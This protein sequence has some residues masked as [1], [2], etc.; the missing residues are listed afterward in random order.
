VGLDGAFGFDTTMWGGAIIA[1][2]RVSTVLFFLPIFGGEG[3]PFRVRVLLGL[4]VTFAIW[5][6]AAATMDSSFLKATS[7]STEL[8][9]ASVREVFL[10]FAIGFSCKLLLVAVSIAAN[11]I[12][13]N[14]GFQ[15]AATISPIFQ[16]QDSVLAV[17]KNW[18]VLVLLLSLN[19]HHRFLELI[20]D[21]FKSVPVSGAIRADL[22]YHNVVNIIQTCFEIGVKIAAP[23]LAIQLLL[24]LSLGLLSRLVPQLN[25]F[26]VN[27]PLSYLVSMVLLF[28][29]LTSIAVVLV[30]ESRS[31]ELL[32]SY[33]TLRSLGGP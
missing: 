26:I 25:V 19:L 2:L 18:F 13:I 6:T 29:A 14:M 30:Q 1:F 11:T 12:G 20:F 8:A 28:F 3:V 9:I 27:F 32:F 5:P 33:R 31:S 16:S 24:T 22:L 10:G 4:V 7:N 17:F 15:T 21:S 23:F